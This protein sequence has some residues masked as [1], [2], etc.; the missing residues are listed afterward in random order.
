MIQ[1]WWLSNR[2]IQ[3]LNSLAQAVW[4]FMTPLVAKLA[5]LVHFDSMPVTL[6]DQ[7]WDLLPLKPDLPAESRNSFLKQ[8]EQYL[9]RYGRADAMPLIQ[10]VF[11]LTD[12][13]YLELRHQPDADRYPH[14]A[15]RIWVSP[16]SDA[17]FEEIK[18]YLT[19]V[20]PARCSKHFHLVQRDNNAGFGRTQFARRFGR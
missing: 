7:Y 19:F 13:E 15:V 17:V 20:L 11:G 8:Y 1:K 12:F 18:R 14:F 3:D 6:R 9:E 2:P 10:E 4:D 5:D 16:V